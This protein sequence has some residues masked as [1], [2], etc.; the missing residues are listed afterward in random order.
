MNII[1]AI[2]N[3]NGIGNKGKIPW[4]I[5]SD[6]SYFKKVTTHTN[7]ILLKNIV[8]MGRKTWDSLPTSV[9][10][11]PDRINIILSKTISEPLFQGGFVCKSMDACFEL[12]Q[13]LEH[14]NKNNIFII[15]GS[16]IY[17]EAIHHKMTQKLYITKVYNTFE[18]D[19]WFPEIDKN[20]YKLTHVSPFYNENNIYYRHLIYNNIK[21]E[22][23]SKDILW[24]NKEEY[25]YINCL[26]KILKIGIEKNDRTGVG[27]LSVFGETF[28]YDLS[29]TFPL[30]TTKKMFVR[31]V[32]EELKFY[33]SGKTD[34]TILNN[35][36]VNIWNGNTTRDF[37]DSRGLSHY[38]VGDM[39]E[40]YGFN[41]RH[42]GA[43]YI[44]CKEDYTGQGFDQLENAI[45][46][47]K[48]DPDSRRI[49]IDIWNC[50][51]IDKS[52]LPPCLC[53]YQFYVDSINNKLDLMI[54]IRSSDFFLANNWNTCT[55]AF[56]VHM[57]CNLQD[58][59]LKPGILTV[60]T[61]D[62]HI[63]KTHLQQVK[64]NIEREPYPFP[65][66]IV[67][68]KKS[69]IMDFEYSDLKLIGYESHS[70]IPAPMAV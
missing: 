47:I 35:K 21:N 25:Q 33:L 38:P 69:N 45:H 1:V 37:L 34:N 10:P 66:L 68:E 51:T 55:G 20:T 17:K 50:S 28:K 61:G 27:T 13:T 19:T 16:H 70:N 14:A 29:D 64:Q 7:T 32:F 54:Y 23:L 42:Y 67:K 60:I 5:K 11:L 53:K 43:K 36:K 52:A 8:I 44:T 39:G 59:H 41:F 40:T 9:K 2:D 49:I 65:K 3:K 31:G 30:L 22:S 26:N 46:L 12:I 4:F 24:K 56:L 62:T 18:C 57:I 15:G 48:N 6:L 58:I 63:Y